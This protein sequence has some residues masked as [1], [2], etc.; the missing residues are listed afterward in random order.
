VYGTSG[1]AGAN[2]YAAEQVQK[3][4]LD[5]FENSVPV[6]KDFEVTD[7]ELRDHDIVF[8]GRPETNSALDFWKAKIGLHYE[9]AVFRVDGKD[10]ASE[11]EALAWAAPNPL[12]AKHMVLVLAGNSPLE[13]VRISKQ[14]PQPEQWVIYKEGK[15][16]LSGF[17]Q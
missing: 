15:E 10:H 7:A 16:T 12:D 5:W 9:F 2:R 8:I 1:E 11:Y 14:A 4:F 17:A 13:T 3:H 6:K